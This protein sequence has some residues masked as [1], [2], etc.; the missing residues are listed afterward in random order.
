MGVIITSGLIAESVVAVTGMV[1]ATEDPLV[2]G[3]AIGEAIMS[4]PAVLSA[5]LESVT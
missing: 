2:E 3:T 4:T 5:W 1:Q